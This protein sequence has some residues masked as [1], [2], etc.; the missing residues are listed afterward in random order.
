[1]MTLQQICTYEIL[2]VVRDNPER[3]IEFIIGAGIRINANE[4]L[5]KTFFRILYSAEV[6]LIV[7]INI[8]NKKSFTNVDGTCTMYHVQLIQFIHGVKRTDVMREY[9]LA[10]P[11][12]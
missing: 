8:A 10:I 9:F 11:F 2:L 1:M 3:I 6:I 5:E 4:K 7:I 12:H